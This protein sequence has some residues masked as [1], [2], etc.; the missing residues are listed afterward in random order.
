MNL[1]AP[2]MVGILLISA[3][4]SL[5]WFTMLTSKDVFDDDATYV[6]YG[7]FKDAAGIRSKTRVQISGIDVGKIDNIELTQRESGQI[8]ARVR[9]RILKKFKLF[10]NSKVSKVA[11]SLL[12]NFRLVVSPGSPDFPV[13]PDGGTIGHVVSTSDMDEIQA[14]LKRV[15][16]HVGEITENFAKVLAGPDGEGSIKGIMAQVEHS[17]AAIDIATTGLANTVSANEQVIGV[18]LRN[19]GEF[20]KSINAMTQPDGHVNAITTDLASL[21]QK[22]DRMATNV[23]DMISGEV[24]DWEGG[25][26]LRDSLDNLNQS[27]MHVTSVMR[28]VDDGQG[29]VG[30]LINDPSL[31]EKVEETLDDASDLVGGISRLEARVVLRTEYSL[32]FES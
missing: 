11:E 25:H 24:G 18:I 12:G 3:G 30:R 32:P 23:D 28:K 20:S 1:K 6:V 7:D 14:Q 26:S 17:M 9:M 22:L 21:T 5:S 15:T 2:L 8:I 27:L 29:S 10:E 4:L 19:L 13:I 31:I 16:T